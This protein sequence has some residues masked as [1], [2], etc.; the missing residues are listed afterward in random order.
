VA[1]GAAMGEAYELNV[2]MAESKT[3]TLLKYMLVGR[4]GFMNYRWWSFAMAKTFC[5]AEDE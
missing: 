4:F 2:K 3:A 5:A 1:P